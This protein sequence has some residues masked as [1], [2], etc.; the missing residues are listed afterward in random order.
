VVNFFRSL[1]RKSAASP[2]VPPKS[3][4]SSSAGKEKVAPEGKSEA[5]GEK[6]AEA[7]AAEL[8]GEDSPT[9]PTHG[10]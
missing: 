6:K 3:D 10:R 1:F 8:R 7:E 2:G 9:Q 5:R 4:T